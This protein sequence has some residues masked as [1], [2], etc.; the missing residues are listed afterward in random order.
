M[1]KLIAD[2][3]AQAEEVIRE[4]KA[5]SSRELRQAF[6]ECARA[7]IEALKAIRKLFN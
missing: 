2:S 4:S 1:M 5:L 6:E 7:Q 3:I